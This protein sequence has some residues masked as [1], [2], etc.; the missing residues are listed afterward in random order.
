[1]PWQTLRL[2]ADEGRGGGLRPVVVDDAAARTTESGT[3]TLVTPSGYR[4][5]GLHAGTL[6]ELLR[7]LG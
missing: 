6:V 4:V 1:V 5:E 7:A 2:W 3:L